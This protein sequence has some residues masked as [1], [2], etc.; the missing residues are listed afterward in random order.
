MSANSVPFDDHTCI[1][2]TMTL[3]DISSFKQ[4]FILAVER[5]LKA[6]FDVSL[7]SHHLILC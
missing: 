3:E 7:V 4:S 5:A 6:G 2:H 1:P